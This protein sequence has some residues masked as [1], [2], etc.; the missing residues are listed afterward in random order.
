MNEFSG[1]GTGPE[2]VEFVLPPSERNHI[3]TATMND[4]LIDD[5]LT[6]ITRRNG[7]SRREAVTSTERHAELVG[8]GWQVALDGKWRS[9]DR[10]DT[11]S[12][13]FDAAW[14]AHTEPTEQRGTTP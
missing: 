7:V 11:R 4:T 5:C 14:T 12:Y 6:W 13:S 2:F 3:M 10:A 1:G 8:A 9:P